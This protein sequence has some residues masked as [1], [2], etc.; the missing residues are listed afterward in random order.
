[1]PKILL[2]ILALLIVV[3]TSISRAEQVQVDDFRFTFAPLKYHPL[4]DQLSDFTVDELAL[5]K[6]RRRI[7]V[8]KVA[9][10]LSFRKAKSGIGMIEE[11]KI[12]MVHDGKINTNPIDA[13]VEAD[14]IENNE[15]IEQAEKI[16]RRH[17][18]LLKIMTSVDNFIFQN[19]RTAIS[20][21]E[22]GLDMALS[23]GS[24]IGIRG[25][26]VFGGALGIQLTFGFDMT[27]KHVIFQF[28]AF[29]EKATGSMTGIF[30]PIGITPR[31]G[32]YMRVSN[33]AP[34]SY[35]VTYV[36]VAPMYV[37]KSNG[38]AGIGATAALTGLSVISGGLA[39]FLESAMAYKT[40]TKTITI[41]DSETIRL[42][43]SKIQDLVGVFK[44]TFRPQPIVCGGSLFL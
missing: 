30:M 21:N 42:K 3:N 32:G 34:T 40:E 5:F 16:N 23:V 31:I 25:K 6:E 44:H 22:Y 36:P 33:R 12:T 7:I 10:V 8:N 19:A 1:M 27:T 17:K 2:I 15:K 18:L 4:R 13:L 20:S 43:F 38:M 24:V 28:K 39:S 35:D 37:T 11:E 9:R 26:R 29:R 41:I 14:A